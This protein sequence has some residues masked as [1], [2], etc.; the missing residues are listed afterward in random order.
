[1]KHSTILSLLLALVGGIIFAHNFDFHWVNVLSLWLISL[2]LLAILFHFKSD[3]IGSRRWVSSSILLVFFFSG[4]LG[5]TLKSP[6]SY[7]NEFSA[8]YLPDDYL[9]GEIIDFQEGKNEYDRA[10]I[11]I[12]KVLSKFQERIVQGQLLCYIKTEELILSQGSVIQFRTPLNPIEN[13]NNPGEFNAEKYWGIQGI[14]YIAFIPETAIQVVGHNSTFTNFWT[15]ARAYLISVVKKYIGEEHQGL[16]IGLSLGDKSL[17]SAETRDHFTN[18]G[19]MHV[20]AVSGMHVGILLSV[21]QVVFK[22]VKILRQRNLYLYFAL[23]FLWCFALVT[24]LPASVSRAV[25]MFS[26]LAIG[27]LAGKKFFSLQAIFGS[28]LV[29][30][31]INPFWLFDIGFQLSYLAVISIGLFFQPIRNLYHS[32]YKVVN[33]LWEGS[34]LGMAAQIGTV[35]ISLIYFH[36]FPN[37]FFLTDLGLVFLAVAALVSVVVFLVF[38]FVPYLVEILAYC[39]DIIFTILHGFISWINTLPAVASIGFTPHPVLIFSF[40]FGILISLYF[41]KKGNLKLI[42]LCSFGLFVCSVLLVVDREQNKFKNELVVLNHYEKLVLVKSNRKLFLCYDEQRPISSDRL[43]FVIQGYEITTGV[44]AKSVAIPANSLVK[45]N[46]NI[47]IS[48]HFEGMRVNYHDK[49]LFLANRVDK[50]KI[51]PEYQ[52][53]KGQWNKFLPEQITDYNTM[54]GALVI[55]P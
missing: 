27:Q 41:W 22:N 18:A 37:Y 45:L 6:S 5:Y 50:T 55:K 23:V 24:G 11:R 10:I 4:A 16:V 32:K 40:Y 17:L 52:I 33:M 49:K 20:L 9:V 46:E 12:D 7:D 47:T 1:M 25:L 3:D 36:Q 35:P 13:S 31:I 53:I 8:F 54:D 34:A 48:N 26:I 38:H 19:A 44:M 14:Q 15:K 2:V 29:L 30:L 21:I 39:V 42:N 43:K 28:A 51:E